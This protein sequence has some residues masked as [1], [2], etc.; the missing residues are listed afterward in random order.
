MIDMQDEDQIQCF[1]CDRIDVVVLA[2]YR[3]HHIEQIASVTQRVIGIDL[4]FANRVFVTRRGDCWHFC[5]QA[6]SRYFTV[7]WITDVGRVV[8]EG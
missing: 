5:D 7:Y 2:R 4:R 3:K 8:I 6:V 1:F